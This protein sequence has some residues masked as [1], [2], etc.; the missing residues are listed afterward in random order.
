MHVANALF[1][2]MLSTPS[3]VVFTVDEYSETWRRVETPDKRVRLVIPE[4]L[5]ELRSLF[6]SEPSRDDAFPFVL[7]AGERRSSTANTLYRDPEWRRGRDRDGALRISPGDAARLGLE[8]GDA[9]RVTTKRGTAVAVV[10]VSDNLQDGHASL[11]NGTGPAYAGGA[12]AGIA[13]NEL[14]A[15]EDKD[16]LARHGTS[17]YGLGSRR[18][19]RRFV[20]STRPGWRFAVPPVKLTPCAS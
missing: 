18:S 16:W 2:T 11:P 19:E 6:T 9:A 17:T 14:T 12:P 4:L 8:D 20:V 13:P 15:S 3:G 7:A 10:E 5:D 1:E